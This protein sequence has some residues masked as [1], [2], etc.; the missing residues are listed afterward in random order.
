MQRH[1]FTGTIKSLPARVFRIRF[2]I[3]LFDRHPVWRTGA[4]SADLDADHSPRR[5]KGGTANSPKGSI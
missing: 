4:V 5:V 1:R 2:E 3:S